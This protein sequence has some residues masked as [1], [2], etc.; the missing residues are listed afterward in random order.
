MVFERYDFWQK[1]YWQK[2]FPIVERWGLLALR[3]GVGGLIDR[4]RSG[5][6]TFLDRDITDRKMFLSL[7]LLPKTTAPVPFVCFACFVVC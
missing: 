2:N 5:G 4:R 1:D 7:N 6:S 3:V